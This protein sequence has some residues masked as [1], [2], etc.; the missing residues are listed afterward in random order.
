MKILVGC[1][2]SQEVTKAF[3]ELGHEAY[4]NDLKECSGGHPEWHL[5]MDVFKAVELIRPELA[6]FHPPCQRL[7]VAANRWYKPEY[8]DRFP[9][10][11]QER[12]EAVTFFS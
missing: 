3:R 11:H 4:S 1:E 10:I 5:Q 7:T 12:E 9:N 2:E 6:I 8:A